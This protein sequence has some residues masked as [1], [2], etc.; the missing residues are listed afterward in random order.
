MYLNDKME[1]TVLHVSSF[2][3]PF[4]M[5]MES[6]VRKVGGQNTTNTSYN[7]TSRNTENSGMLK[8]IKHHCIFSIYQH[9]FVTGI[10]CILFT[11]CTKLVWSP[12]V[13]QNASHSSTILSAMM[14]VMLCWITKKVHKNN[15]QTTN[16]R[17]LLQLTD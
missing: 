2:K 3:K 14:L 6:Y 9:R 16:D 7:S 10:W 13:G 1:N 5:N 17:F 4:Q 8:L 11:T 12:F 15:Y